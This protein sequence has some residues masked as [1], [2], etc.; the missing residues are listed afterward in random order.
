MNR[1]ARPVIGCASNSSI[2]PRT[3]CFGV[4]CIGHQAVHHRAPLH[5][6]RRPA[7]YRRAA[8]V[9]SFTRPVPVSL[10]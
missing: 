2:V 6:N 4:P 3:T 5:L 8:Y 10:D 9:P 1:P 7:E